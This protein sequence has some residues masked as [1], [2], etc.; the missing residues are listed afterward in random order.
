MIRYGS[1]EIAAKARE[2]LNSAVIGGGPITADFA[3]DADI[4][5]FFEQ[6]MDWSSNPFPA[7]TFGSQWSFQNSPKNPAPVDGTAATAGTTSLQHPG[8]D[9]KSAPGMPWGAGGTV[10]VPSQL[11]GSNQGPGAVGSRFMAP[12]GTTGMWS[13]GAGFSRDVEPQSG[14]NENGLVS[15]S[16]TTFLPPGLL[17]GGESA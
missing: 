7:N 16:M 1:K 9:D 5:S 17:N 6:T 8:G 12:Q 14:S 10:P 2:S 11:W 15:P 4:G 13:F 3:T